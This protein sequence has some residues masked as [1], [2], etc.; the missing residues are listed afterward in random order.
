[1]LTELRWILLWILWRRWN[2]SLNCVVLFYERLLAIF[3]SPGLCI[4]LTDELVTKP[5]FFAWLNWTAALSLAAQKCQTPTDRQRGTMTTLQ[6]LPP[7]PKSLQALLCAGVAQWKEMEKT[8][9]LRTLIQQQLAE[10]NSSN[11]VSVGRPNGEQTEGS[12][13]TTEA[14]I[15]TRPAV[16]TT[17]Y[18]ATSRGIEA[19][20]SHLHQ[21]MVGIFIT[22]P[23]PRP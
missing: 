13:D 5:A 18:P 1:M 9:Q 22:Q 21:E 14:E 11:G 8:H 16:S 23:C 6:G 12:V 10:E 7:L 2:V 20:I 4:D 15:P 3:N 17:Y 19:A